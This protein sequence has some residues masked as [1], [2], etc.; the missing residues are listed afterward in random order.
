MAISNALHTLWQPIVSHALEDALA[1]YPQKT[2]Q[3]QLWN[4]ATWGAPNDPRFTIVLNNP[5]ALRRL[6]VDPNELSIGE[7]YIAG[8]FDVEGD[9]ASAFDL[10]DYLFSRVK[11][12]GISHALLALFD[13]NKEKD[14]DD[15]EDKLPS[16]ELP[17]DGNQHATLHG[18][19]HSRQ[20]DLQAIR[21]HYDLP[22][23]FFSLWL[24]TRMMYSCAYFAD[25][26]NADLEAAQVSKLEYI[27]KK[28]R[29][30]PGDHLLD[31]GCG[32]GGLVVYAAAH[33]GVQAHGI[34]L[35]L[36]Q[37]EV[38]RQRI[39]DAGLDDQCRVEVCDYRD[40]EST[41]PF[42]KI[43]SIGMFEHVGKALLPEYFQ[44]AWQL[45][46]PGGVFL[47][48]GIASALA[49]SEKT[50]PSFVDKYV[51]PDGELVPIHIT[52][53]AA[54]VS[55]FE[56]RDVENLREHYAMT[57]HHWVQRLEAHAQE[58]RNLTDETTYRIWRLYM[59]GSE[60]QF[61]SGILHLYQI[62][63]AKPLHG[64]TEMPLTR[65]D[66]YQSLQ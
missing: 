35:S 12:Q 16:H 55:G 58:A 33:Y 66:W 36:R 20:R 7:A 53:G 28:L 57:L 19:V 22:P 30:R 27:C 61:L 29:L 23:D 54:E 44:R 50:G 40:I 5:E 65:A 24:D 1:E 10:G 47:N 45:L 64:N 13:K 11:A 62:L 2:F 37:A 9:L 38:A 52:I 21:Y 41:Q 43:V 46:R 51:F 32:W 26:D 8:D 34:T 14:E 17:V 63:L 39:H 49:H 31:V 15:D 3:V 56:V 6:F 59:S 18:P 42:D 4:G 25:G 48:S 60:H